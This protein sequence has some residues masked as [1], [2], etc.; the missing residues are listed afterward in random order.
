MGVGLHHLEGVSKLVSFA[1]DWA[2][3]Y[4]RLLVVVHLLLVHSV[5]VHVMQLL[6]LSQ[7]DFVITARSSLVV[8]IEARRVSLTINEV[9]LNLEV[10][11]VIVVLDIS[12]HRRLIIQ[13]NWMPAMLCSQKWIHG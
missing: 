3:S 5:L 2:G 11:P 1:M 13:R 7:Q 6:L 10:F 4:E 9:G 12:F 8:P